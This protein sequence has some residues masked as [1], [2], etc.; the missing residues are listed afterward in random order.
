[1]VS[2]AGRARRVPVLVVLA[3]LVAGLVG[4]CLCAPRQAE[5]RAAHDCCDGAMGLKAAAPDCCAACAAT[6]SAPEAAFPENAHSA[7]SSVVALP[8]RVAPAALVV[9]VSGRDASFPTSPPLT[10]LRI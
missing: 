6:L 8:L 7:I 4:P 3:A 1:M 5:A 10:T 9:T 2:M